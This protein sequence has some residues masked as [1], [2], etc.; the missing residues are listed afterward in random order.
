MKLC[1]MR[2]A[3]VLVTLTRSRLSI[4]VIIATALMTDTVNTLLIGSSNNMIIEI[5]N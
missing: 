4:K 5:A 3:Y 2:A 1:T